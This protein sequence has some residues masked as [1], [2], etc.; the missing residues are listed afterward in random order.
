MYT[1]RAVDEEKKLRRPNAKITDSEKSGIKWFGVYIS[2]VAY[3]LRGVKNP[4]YYHDETV[5]PDGELLRLNNRRILAETSSTSGT[6]P[7][8]TENKRS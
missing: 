7:T 1:D 5:V 3:P 6:T 8:N 4:I 2:Q